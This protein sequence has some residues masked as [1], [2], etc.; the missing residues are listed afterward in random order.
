MIGHTNMSGDLIGT[1]SNTSRALYTSPIHTTPHTSHSH[2]QHTA[3]TPPLQHIADAYTTRDFTHTH[4]HFS[5][6]CSR[7]VWVIIFLFPLPTKATVIIIIIIP[8]FREHPS[9]TGRLRAHTA[10]PT[11]QDICLEL[12]AR[13]ES[14]PGPSG[15]C[16]VLR[17][18]S[19]HLQLQPHQEP[20]GDIYVPHPSLSLWPTDHWP[21]PQKEVLLHSLECRTRS[22]L[23][24]GP[25]LAFPT[26][27]TSLPEGG[28]ESSQH[29]A[30]V[31][32]L[33]GMPVP[34]HCPSLQQPERLETLSST[35]LL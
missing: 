4:T 29:A 7:A 33:V 8:S 9:R 22:S 15:L 26:R 3:Q 6:E 34:P 11:D 28:R 5:S 19:C 35:V 21:L 14:C 20:C 31:P 30:V 1:P 2:T 23:G 13:P 10:V 17:N 32:P 25:S 12:P 24:S 18:A 27:L 16:P